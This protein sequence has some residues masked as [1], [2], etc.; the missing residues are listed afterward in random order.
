[1]VN[2]IGQTGL[3]LFC[4]KACFALYNIAEYDGGG[5]QNRCIEGSYHR[6]AH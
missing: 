2:S 6:F 4:E 3:R 1:M 5:I